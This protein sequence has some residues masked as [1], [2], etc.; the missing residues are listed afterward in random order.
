MPDCRSL[1]AHLPSLDLPLPLDEFKRLDMGK[2]RTFQNCIHKI[3]SLRDGRAV[4]DKEATSFKRRSSMWQNKP[5]FR[6]IQRNRIKFSFI[7][8][9]INVFVDNLD[10]L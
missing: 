4:G 6:H 10:I 8:P 3:S 1:G 2:M 9:L 5:G 7:D